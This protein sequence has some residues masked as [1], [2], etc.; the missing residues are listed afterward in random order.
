MLL[1]VPLAC[2]EAVC[3]W[4]CVLWPWAKLSS[5]LTLPILSWGSPS[6]E[7]PEQGPRGLAEGSQ[8]HSDV[9]KGW[10]GFIHWTNAHRAPP[11]HGTF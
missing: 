10:L 8:A 11:P 4:L 2:E 6:W 1:R 7:F 3:L 5:I 9:C